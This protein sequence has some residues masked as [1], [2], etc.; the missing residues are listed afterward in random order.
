MLAW[1]QQKI[2]P[3][4]ARKQGHSILTRLSPPKV[5]S[6]LTQLLPPKVQSI[7][8]PLPASSKGP[9]NINPAVSS[10]GPFNIN[11]VVPKKGPFNINPAAVS[12]GPSVKKSDVVTDG[13]YQGP[14]AH[15][16]YPQ[17]T[18]HTPV[19]LSDTSTSEAKTAENSKSSPIPPK[20]AF[21]AGLPKILSTVSLAQPKTQPL[22]KTLT[23]T[24]PKPSPE[25]PLKLDVPMATSDKTSA[26]VSPI[27]P[28]KTTAKMEELSNRAAMGLKEYISLLANEIKQTCAGVLQGDP[29]SSSEENKDNQ[30]KP[31]EKSGVESAISKKSE[32]VTQNSGTEGAKSSEEVPLGEKG[33]RTMQI[34]KSHQDIGEKDLESETRSGHLKTAS[35]DAVSVSNEEAVPNTAPSPPHDAL[36]IKWSKQ[37]LAH[38]DTAVENNETETTVLEQKDTSQQQ[39]STDVSDKLKKIEP[40]KDVVAKGIVDEN[41][42][43]SS[44]DTTQSSADSGF[45]ADGVSEPSGGSQELPS[46]S[47]STSQG[48][49]T[50]QEVA[51]GDLIMESQEMPSHTKV[52]SQS[53]DMQSMDSTDQ[54][55]AD[56][57][58]EP[59]SQEVPFDNKGVSLTSAEMQSADPT[60]QE[61]PE[62]GDPTD[63]ATSDGTGEVSSQEL[64]FDNQV[65]SSSSIEMQSTDPTT[66]QEMPDEAGFQS[67]STADMQSVDQ[68]DPELTGDDSNAGVA[69]DVSSMDE[70]ECAISNI[71]QPSRTPSPQMVS[72]LGG[73]SCMEY[74][75]GSE[76]LVNN[77]DEEEMSYEDNQEGYEVSQG[78]GDQESGVTVN[79]NVSNVT[80]NSPS[81]S[82]DSQDVYEPSGD[83]DVSCN[84]SEQSQDDY[85]TSQVDSES[86]LKPN[87]DS[88]SQQSRAGGELSLCGDSGPESS[89]APDADANQNLSEETEY[90]LDKK[91]KVDLMSC[92]GVKENPDGTMRVVL[93]GEY[94]DDAVEEFF[95]RPDVMDYLEKLA[96]KT[97][98]KS[99]PVN[100]LL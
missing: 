71:P 96:T 78:I 65:A 69:D 31:E 79:L 57:A 9:S 74:G 24:L 77:M 66:D 67:P 55:M 75:V 41:Q 37:N 70:T 20:P 95:A 30:T 15:S 85:Q 90:E 98:Q 52:D 1:H 92:L 3:K 10:K 40:M 61:M 88:D 5:H 22:S 100:N 94:D 89:S 2:H 59:S 28:L 64:P 49:V 43:S 83:A 48:T 87:V 72:T 50:D 91:P 84:A 39:T 62:E 34:E 16:T 17:R 47:Q 32:Q 80:R 18:G 19:L 42:G 29:K 63:Q 12:K 13:A 35:T 56:G 46:D 27:S 81:R 82:Y 36:N 51:D 33:E 25:D 76:P 97:S 68:V 11:P 14:K 4:R 99:N 21:H 38:T 54:E 8:T 86:S 45:Q 73:Y 53:V 93:Q 7:L 60:D 58:G 44:Q 6:I 26:P 23:P